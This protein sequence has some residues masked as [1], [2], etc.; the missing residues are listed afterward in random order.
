[1]PYSLNWV[2]TMGNEINFKI[3]YMAPK[4]YRLNQGFMWVT[5]GRNNGYWFDKKLRVWT[6]ERTGNDM[7]SC[8]EC[9]SVK[10]FKRMLR[11]NHQILELKPILAHRQYL[12]KPF[13]SSLD[14]YAELEKERWIM[15][16][17]QKV[18]DEI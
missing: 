14:V 2:K 16:K 8:A 5:L 11:K 3:K 4:G 15:M 12:V 10:A 17:K 13:H 6:K 9:R 7:S 1:M 18:L